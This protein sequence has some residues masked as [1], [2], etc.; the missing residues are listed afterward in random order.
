MYKHAYMCNEK[1]GTFVFF[2]YKRTW[3]ISWLLFINITLL[4]LLL[5]LFLLVL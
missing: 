4:L 2:S 1:Q 3:L 5:L